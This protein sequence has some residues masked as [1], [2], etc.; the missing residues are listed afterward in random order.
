MTDD[1]RVWLSL[2]ASVGSFLAS[3]VVFNIAFDIW[4]AWRNPHHNSMAG[5]TAFVIGLPVG[6]VF[7]VVGFIVTYWY[8]G[9]KA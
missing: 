9:R 5:L 2:K 1:E 7:W 6:V 3:F 8:T 4:A